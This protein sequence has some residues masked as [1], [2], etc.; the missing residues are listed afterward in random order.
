MY[1]STFRWSI[2]SSFFPTLRNVPPVDI[3]VCNFRILIIPILRC[4]DIRKSSSVKQELSFL[5][6]FISGSP[7]SC[8]FV[9]GISDQKTDLRMHQVPWVAFVA[10]TFSVT[11]FSSYFMV[12]QWW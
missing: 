3:R 8:M 12:S 1:L 7:A 2:A 10:L 6:L 4:L 11:F 5:V 9:A